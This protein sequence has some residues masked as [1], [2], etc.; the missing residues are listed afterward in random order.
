MFNKTK[1]SFLLSSTSSNF[2]ACALRPS[3]HKKFNGQVQGNGVSYKKHY[4]K[5]VEGM[6]DKPNTPKNQS[7]DQSNTQSKILLTTLS[8]ES[9]VRSS[10]SPES[11][12]LYNGNSSDPLGSPPPAHLGGLPYNL[13][14]DGGKGLRS[15][16]YS[17]PSVP[18]NASSP[19]PGYPYSLLGGGSGGEQF[20]G[21][22]SSFSRFELET[23]PPPTPPHHINHPILNGNHS[24]LSSNHSSNSRSLCPN[25]SSSSSSNRSNK[26]TTSSGSS[27]SSNSSS[28]SSSSSASSKTHIKKPLN[29]F[30]LYMKEM[31]PT[32][33]AECTLKES[34]AINQIL[35]RRWHGLSRE[36]QAKYYESARKERQLHMQM[37]PGWSARDNYAQNK[38]K[39]RKREGS[40]SQIKSSSASSVLVN[41]IKKCRARYGMDQQDLWCKPCNPLTLNNNNNNLSSSSN[42]NSLNTTTPA[43]PDP[44]ELFLHHHH[45]VVSSN[46]EEDMPSS[47]ISPP[48][49]NQGSGVDHLSSHGQLDL[50]MSNTGSLP[51][52]LAPL[53]DSTRSN[54]ILDHHHPLESLKLHQHPLPPGGSIGDESSPNMSKKKCSHL[55]DTTLC[56]EILLNVVQPPPPLC[57]EE[58]IGS[59]LTT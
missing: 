22:C 3:P 14:S 41:N 55:S 47:P 26:K 32:I 40:S 57:F 52:P 28:S 37:Y 48:L 17:P 39:K 54:H 21:S 29:A 34:A 46:Q 51:P 49:Q 42:N 36:E 11:P 27:G 38:K 18:P 6:S 4:L 56:Q 35:G 15:A 7:Y 20:G 43:T 45:R 50:S 13:A 30:M 23:I 53:H 1:E 31:R 9:H 5:N 44:R 2:E 25:S 16:L 19:S 59:T 12:Y 8:T 33:V 24:R 58:V 10:E